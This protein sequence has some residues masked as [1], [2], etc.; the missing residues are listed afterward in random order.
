MPK[1]GYVH[2]STG[3]NV[4]E[5]SGLESLTPHDSSAD[6]LEDHQRLEVG[7]LWSSSSVSPRPR[8]LS[9]VGSGGSTTPTS[10]S[11]DSQLDDA[12]VVQIPLHTDGKTDNYHNKCADQFA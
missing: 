4:T 2:R 11:S 10:I 9:S 7:S 1:P 3:S 6:E 8:M 12:R 5:D